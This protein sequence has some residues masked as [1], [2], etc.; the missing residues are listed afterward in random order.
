MPRNELK[1][2]T[3]EQKKWHKHRMEWRENGIFETE[4]EQ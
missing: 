1:E 2:L 4:H 3:D